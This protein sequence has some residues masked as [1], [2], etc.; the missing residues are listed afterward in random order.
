MPWLCWNRGLWESGPLD[1]PVLRNKSEEMPYSWTLYKPKQFTW[2]PIPTP[3]WESDWY[4]RG[5]LWKLRSEDF[6]CGKWG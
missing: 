6:P 1:T 3:G 4:Q 2:L 5:D